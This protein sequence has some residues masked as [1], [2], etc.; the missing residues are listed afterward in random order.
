MLTQ[1]KACERLE[2]GA[3]QGPLAGSLVYPASP[4]PDGDGEGLRL[5]SSAP[6]PA[7]EF[8]F[9]EVLSAALQDE[10]REHHSLPCAPGSVPKKYFAPRVLAEHEHLEVV[11]SVQAAPG[12][13]PALGAAGS[14]PE[15]CCRPQDG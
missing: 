8:T 9:E 13:D 6:V 14:D 1:F 4:M 15:R 5:Y 10:L 11:A 2:A 12:P 3:S 7:D